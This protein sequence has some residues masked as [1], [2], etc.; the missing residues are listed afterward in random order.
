MKKKDIIPLTDEENKFY[1]E[2]KVCNI[3]KKGFSIDNDKK[4]HKVRDHCHYTGKFRGA[5][6]SICNL[7][8]KTPKE[9]PIVFHNGSTYDYHFIINKLAKE[10]DGQLECLGENTEKYIIFSLPISK[11][12]DIG[13]AI[14]YRLKFIDSF[15]FVS[16]SLSSLVDNFSEIYKKESKVCEERRKIKSV[17]NFIRLNNNNLN[18]EC[19][20]CKK[21][22][23]KPV[24]EL[25]KKFPNA[26]QFCN[27][28]TNQFILL[29]RKGVYPYKHI[30]SWE[31]FNEASLPDKK[32][33]LQ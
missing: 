23:L 6:H 4:H 18:Y 30:D 20:E 10:F 21:R 32:N 25:I 15:T 2:Q 9:I 3:C 1:E 33:Y 19:K 12:L 31:R 22:S 24:N 26:Y 8:Y 7:R 11:E 13:K 16:T 5:A 29:L 27:G 17:C 14:K 28:D